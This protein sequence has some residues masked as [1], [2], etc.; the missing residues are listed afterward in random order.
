MQSLARISTW[1]EMYYLLSKELLCWA[2]LRS[3]E[4]FCNCSVKMLIICNQSVNYKYIVAFK[5]VQ[6]G[7]GIMLIQE[8]I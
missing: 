1:R 3:W 7:G 4:F 5:L 6:L 8:V 2:I